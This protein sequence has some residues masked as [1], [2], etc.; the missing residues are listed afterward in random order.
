[1]KSDIA[2]LSGVKSLSTIPF[3]KISAEI[4]SNHIFH[5]DGRGINHQT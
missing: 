2:A 1:M 5:C 3:E 4:K